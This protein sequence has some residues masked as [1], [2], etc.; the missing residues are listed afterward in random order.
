MTHSQDPAGLGVNTGQSPHLEAVTA[1]NPGWTIGLNAETG[2]WEATQ[3]P[4]ATR[5]ILVHAPTL[6]ELAIELGTESSESG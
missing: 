5:L 4:T 6:A 1:A 3:R 2:H